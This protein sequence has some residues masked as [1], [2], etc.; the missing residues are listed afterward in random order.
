[1]FT[2][3]VR[4]LNFIAYLKTN[5][6]IILDPQKAQWITSDGGGNLLRWE[7]GKNL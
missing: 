7:V 1:M 5:N 4:F 6:A 3:E 2:D